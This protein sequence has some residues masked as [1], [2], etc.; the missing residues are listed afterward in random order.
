[1]TLA[2]ITA[3]NPVTTLIQNNGI[4]FLNFALTPDLG[5]GTVGQF[6]RKTANGPLL[7]LS[8]EDETGRYVLP[9][10]QG[11]HPEVVKPECGFALAQ[12]LR[13]L[14]DIWLPLPF[15]RVNLPR[16]FVGGPD[17]RARLRIVALDS[18]DAQGKTHRLVLAFE[19]RTT[20]GDRDE[21]LAL[22]END[23]RSGIHFALAYRSHELGEFLDHTWI[24][25]WLRETFQQ[26]ATRLEQ[27][28][29]ESIATAL[30]EFEYQAHY[31]NVLHVLGE[32]LALPLLKVSTATQ[33]PPPVPVDL[34]L[35]AGNAHTCGIMVEDHE[36]DHQGLKHTYELQ[37]R[38][39]THPHTI[40]DE[41]FESRV[42]FSQPHFGKQNFSVESGRS[43]AFL[44]PS[45]TRVGSEATTLAVQR[46]GNE[47]AS[48]ISN[49]RRYLWDCDRYAPGWR[50]GQ[51]SG[52]SAS[53]AMAIAPPLMML[54]NDEGEPLYQQPVEERLPVFSAHYSRSSMMRFMLI[55]LLAQALMQMNSPQQRQK[56]L[57]SQAPRQ[58]R[59]I[60]LTLPCAMPHQEREILRQRMQEAI[61]L[62]WKSMGWHDSD[63]GLPA[64]GAGTLFPVPDIQMAWDEAT[65]GQMVYLYN[66]TQVNFSGQAADFFASQARPDRPLAPG[67][68]PGRT[69]RI[70]SIDIGGGTTDLAITAFSLDEGNSHDVSIVPE[71][72]FREGFRLAGDDILLDVIQL[73]VLP[74]LQSALTTA[75]VADPKLTM[76]R[77]FGQ[78]GRIDGYS[79]LRQQVTLQIF[80]PLGQAILQAYE[81]YDPE[82]LEAEV[83]ALFGELLP[84]PPTATLHQQINGE[85][86]RDLP[87]DAPT[88]DIL[89]VLMVVSLNQLHGEFLSSRLRICQRLRSLAEVVAV[90][91]C[92][93]LLLTGR[94]PRFPGIQAL[95][96]HLQPL[97]VNRMLSL[98]GY[99][100]SDWYPFNKQGTIDNPKSTA[101]VGAMLCLLSLELRL[102]NFWF[103][104]ADFESYSTVRYLGV[105]DSNEMLSE[106]NVW[107]A[108]IDLDDT[109]GR[110][111]QQQSFRVRGSVALGFRQL[112]NA[113]WPAAPLYMLT[114][115]DAQLARRIASDEMLKVKLAMVKPAG[116]PYP[117]QFMLSEAR[118]SDGSAVPLEQLQLKLNTLPG[119]GSGITHYW[120]DSGSVFKK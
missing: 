75:G 30:R 86:Q 42:E 18:P 45:M 113:R 118:L 24:D 21:S 59:H 66:E 71:L 72:L 95:F 20:P 94:P 32:Q 89:Q 60:I 78:E 2:T 61:V 77:L 69:L 43:D 96:R 73:Y 55:E 74:A 3:F 31:L 25:G 44:W 15:F 76:T 29:A 19:T 115:A 46:D 7:R 38:N 80:I 5:A 11:G 54:M 70:A 110:L 99:H 79:T 58:L 119:S 107:Y 48:G 53:E 81:N 112:E 34:I 1:M 39:F 40:C 65:C 103:K 90:H 104:A 111:E 84:Q 17:N 82:Q 4:Q 117:T 8:L 26:Q 49:P 102:A 100:T 108:D 33:Q 13:L 41:L 63:D 10:V 23:A 85:I 101:A 97:P 50:F 57:H 91:D 14:N 83:E 109:Q 22:T 120:L 105:L 16:T 47:G 56:M 87:G 88:F 37:L 62:V 36:N 68:Q 52:P 35:D 98:D 114:L 28:S 9:N 12:S 116:S 67:E 106:E 6:V 64:S 92:D 93:V 27:R 51:R